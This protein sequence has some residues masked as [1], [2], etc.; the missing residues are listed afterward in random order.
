MYPIAK[1][2]LA[3]VLFQACDRRIGRYASATTQHVLQHAWKTALWA[4]KCIVST[5]ASALT[6]VWE[7]EVSVYHV[8]GVA[9]TE[10][11]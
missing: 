8:R 7:K 3:H 5:G 9:S 10:H 4:G 1:T 11:N 2:V 6:R